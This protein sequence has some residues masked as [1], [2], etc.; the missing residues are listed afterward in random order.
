MRLAMQ[1]KLQKIRALDLP[2]DD[3]GYTLDINNKPVH[4]DNNPTLCKYNT[5]LPLTNKHIEEIYKCSESIFYFIENYVQIFT[6]DNGWIVPDLRSYQ[7]DILGLYN[8]KR[9]INILAGRQSGKSA[10]TNLYI[11]W[12]ILFNSDTIVGMAAN[13]QDMSKENLG[14]LKEY[15]ENLPIWLKVGVKVWNATY[16][17]L[18]NGSK[19]YTSAASKTS[20]RG[21]GISICW[22]DEVSFLPKNIWDDFSSSVLPT[23]SSGSKS[24]VINTST[25]KGTSNQWYHMWRGGST[26]EAT[27]SYTNYKVEWYDVPGRDQAWKDNMIKTLTGGAVEFAQEFACDFQG[28][29]DTLVDISALKS[30]KAIEPIYCDQF[31]KGF[32]QFEELNESSNYI[33]SVDPSKD[34]KDSFSI[35]VIDISNFPFKQVAVAN[36]MV[37]YLKMPSILLEIAEYYNHAFV[38]IENN[39]GAG[40][41]IADKLYDVYEYDHMYKDKLKQFY[42]FRT[43]AK[44]R[45]EILSHLKIFIENGKLIIHDKGTIDQLF[46]FI[47][48]NGKYQADSGAHD[49]LVMSLA[50]SFAPF[51]NNNAFSNYDTFIKSLELV[52]NTES[53]DEVMKTISIGYFDDG[54]VEESSS[55]SWGDLDNIND[56]N[57]R[58]S[59]DHNP[60]FDNQGW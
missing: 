52:D 29:S 19:V 37:N 53:D 48:K 10:S 4:L 27:T 15:Y 16:I 22:I 8:E 35:Q 54:I 58:N 36:L 21:L 41:S 20:F 46:N 12:K 32:N 7:Y 30:L 6:L 33:V 13:K 45:R 5:K 34:G 38:V 56:F 25:P 57:S 11:L 14:R 28:S 60:E 44:T 42:G 1:T 2:V 31:I 59:F 26:E 43:T 3:R 51:L 18:E 55:N 39:E 47:S 17:S 50:I 24:Q 9:F 40:Q 23:I 49:D